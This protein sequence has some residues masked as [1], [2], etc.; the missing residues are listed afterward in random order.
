MCCTC[1]AKLLEGEVKHAQELRA[2]AGATST[3]ASC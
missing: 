2:G 3:P 1:R